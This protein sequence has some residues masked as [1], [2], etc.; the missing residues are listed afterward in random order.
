MIAHSAGHSAVGADERI[1]Q[2]SDWLCTELHFRLVRLEPAS[3]DA[4]FR[5]YF[6][7]WRADGATRVVMD[8]PPDKEPIEPF[9]KVAALLSGSGVHVPQV[10][11]AEP[12][13]GFVLLEDLGSVLYL[14]RLRAGDDPEPLYADA[15][16]ALLQMQV[17]LPGASSLDAY[18]RAVLEREMALM[19]EWF[20]THHLQLSLEREEQALLAQTFELLSTEALAQPRVFVHRDYHSRNLLLLDQR[21]PGIVDFQDALFGPVTYDLVSLL[22]DCYI[23]WPRERITRWV[24]DYRSRLAAAGGAPGASEQQFLRWFDL[25]GLQR[26]LKVLGIFARLWWRDGKSGYLADLP[27]T[28]QYVRDAAGRYAELAAFAAWLERRVAPALAPANARA[29]RQA[30]GG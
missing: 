24:G 28:L 3:S 21:N 11:A 5:R 23:D 27:R 9:L 1:E 22:K 4:S 10:D 12:R 14:T 18:D 19:P 16:Q 25:I 15:L 26:H 17:A 7:A 13:R 2:L 20:C 30:A 8:A 29:L 6:R